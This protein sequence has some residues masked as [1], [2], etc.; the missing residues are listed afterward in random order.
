MKFVSVMVVSEAD[1]Q[2]FN[3]IVYRY[4]KTSIL[5]GFEQCRF[6]DV[7]FLHPANECHLLCKCFQ[8]S[9]TLHSNVCSLWWPCVGIHVFT[10]HNIFKRNPAMWI[11]GQGL[12]M[13]LSVNSN[14]LCKF[15]KSRFA[16]RAV[17]VTLVS[18]K[19]ALRPA[20]LSVLPSSLLITFNHGALQFNSSNGS[21]DAALLRRKVSSHNK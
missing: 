15:W 14:L 18:G 11:T 19:V 3:W 1:G 4:S 17:H 5:K 8:V 21:L 12:L 20:S 2:A 10:G 7:L 13:R 6:L 16:C 9:N